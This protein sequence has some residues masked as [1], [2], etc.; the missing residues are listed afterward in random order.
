ML[1]IFLWGG[2]FWLQIRATL[3][4]DDDTVYAWLYLSLY[5]CDNCYYYC[6]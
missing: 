4:C 3:W 2:F 6:L 5:Y 1:V